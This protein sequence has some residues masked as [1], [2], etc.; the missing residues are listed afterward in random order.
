MTFNYYAKLLALDKH[1]VFY[2]EE[3]N[4]LTFINLFLYFA[5]YLNVNFKS[6]IYNSKLLKAL[7]QICTKMMSKYY[8]TTPISV[9]N[10]DIINTQPKFFEREPLQEFK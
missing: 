9:N 10:K 4:F 2:V 8:N 3:I 1:L 7:R 5:I 6:L